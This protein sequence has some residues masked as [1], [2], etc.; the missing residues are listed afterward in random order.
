MASISGSFSS[1]TLL[2]AAS[3][4]TM[5]P[6]KLSISLMSVICE[7]SVSSGSDSLLMSS[8]VLPS[9]PF[10]DSISEVSILS[11]S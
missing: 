9:F 5:L 8:A 7:L 3:I 10:T 1:E 11:P 4:S 6:D 2:S